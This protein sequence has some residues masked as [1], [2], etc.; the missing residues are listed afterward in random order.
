MMW[1]CQEHDIEI[2]KIIPYHKERAHPEYFQKLLGPLQGDAPDVIYM[3]S[4][5]RDA[6]FIVKKIRELNINS[7]LV[8]GAGGF[9]SHKFIA[10]A[11]SSADNLLT[12][13]LWTPHLPYAG[14]K[15]YYDRYVQRYDTPP[16]YHGAEAYSVLLVAAD[17]LRRAQSLNPEDIRA[18]LDKTDMKTA[19]GPVNFKSY[20]KF[21][22]QNSLPT[23][24]L[25]IIND[26]YESVWPGSIA[27]SKFIP[28]SNWRTTKN[29]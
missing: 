21:S 26:K 9:T 22:R 24:V 5:L 11:G 13:T 16:D 12:A 27:T 7:I 18:A 29:K 3:V 19:F 2:S 25:Q 23:M 17:A 8:G 14:T 15:E 4:Y 28:P 6:V 1:F 10:M 20:G